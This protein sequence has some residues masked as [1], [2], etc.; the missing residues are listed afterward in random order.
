VEGP[1]KFGR[2][3]FEGLWLIEQERHQDERG[4]FA[5]L[6]CEREFSAHV[7]WARFVQSSLSFNR[8]RGT[9]RG[10]H[11]QWPP[12]QEA[13]LVRCLRGE[14]F[15]AVVDLRPASP[16]FTRHY[17]VHLT[18]DNGLALYV[19]DG[20]AHG[21]Q[22]LRDATEIHYSMTD[23]FDPELADGFWYADPHFGI[24][25]P[26]PVTRVSDRDRDAARFE[27]RQYCNDHA[28]RVAAARARSS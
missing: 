26:E 28:R 22:V 12:S 4:Y 5:R 16:T 9:V 13:K 15:D 14:A 23:Y 25:W 8:H 24:A 3:E 1:V 6:H 17:T 27:V 11:F 19:P 2:T 21:F 7:T 18:A 10:L 20:F